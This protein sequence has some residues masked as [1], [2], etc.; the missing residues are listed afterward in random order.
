MPRSMNS[1]AARRERPAQAARTS[2]PVAFVV[3]SSGADGP[4]GAGTDAEHAARRGQ[5]R[6]AVLGAREPGQ[7]ALARPS[8]SSTAGVT[9]SSPSSI[10]ACCAA[11][12]SPMRSSTI[13]FSGASAPRRS[14]SAAWMPAL[15]IR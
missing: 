15:S 7:H 8:T 5:E 9:S 6:Q 3:V 13:P 2:L 4:P 14:S 11:L 1:P 10:R 12:I